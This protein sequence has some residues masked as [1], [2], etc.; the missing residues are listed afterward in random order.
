MKVIIFMLVIFTSNSSMA[1]DFYKCVDE[2][3]N[4]SFSDKPCQ[5]TKVQEVGKYKA[6]SLED[7]LIAAAKGKSKVFSVTKDGDDTLIDYRFSTNAELQE[8]MRTSQKLSGQNINL[9]KVVM[10]QEANLGVALLQITDKDDG[11]LSTK[12]NK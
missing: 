6:T 8:F 5:N 2:R 4:K 1:A 7:Q 10:P 3:G 11:F 12:P 9:L